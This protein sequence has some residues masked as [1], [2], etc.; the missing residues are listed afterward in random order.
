EA[1]P[2]RLAD[3]VRWVEQ[4]LTDNRVMVCCRAGM[5]RSVS[6]VMAYLCCV[7]NMAYADVLKLVL[8]RRPGAMPL[9][10]LEDAI[11]R[12]LILRKAA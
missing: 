12:V 4:H 1:D 7:E 10:N 5:G 2:K 11:E 6:V 9:P 8:T 3:A